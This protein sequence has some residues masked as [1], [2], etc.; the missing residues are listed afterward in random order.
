MLVLGGEQHLN[1]VYVFS[2]DGEAVGSVLSP[3][4]PETV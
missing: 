1:H 2:G 3:S 4:V